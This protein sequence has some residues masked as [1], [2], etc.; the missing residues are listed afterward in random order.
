MP[1]SPRSSRQAARAYIE[2]RD[3]DEATLDHSRARAAAAASSKLQQRM[4]QAREA[5]ESAH[6]AA[7]LDPCPFG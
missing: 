7:A 6:A 5:K 4:K 2:H 1:T 3:L